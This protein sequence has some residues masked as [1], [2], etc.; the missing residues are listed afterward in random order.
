[1]ASLARVAGS[2]IAAFGGAILAPLLVYLGISIPFPATALGLVIVALV[3]AILCRSFTTASI[4]SIAGILAGLIVWL[5]LIYNP[6]MDAIVGAV[7]G[8]LL[9]DPTLA[10]ILLLAAMALVS[11]AV[12]LALSPR[13]EV[14]KAA[15]E[16]ESEEGVAVE[17]PPAAESEKS[18]A[19][20]EV[21]AVE[22]HRGEAPAVAAEVEAPTAGEEVVYVKCIHCGEPVPEEAVYCPHCGKRVKA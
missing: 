11:G 22:P 18:V 16:R 17:V 8:N 2:I 14:I 12:G 13:E 3:P 5:T 15:L 1:M 19:E 10:Y 6:V 4:A 9:V 7:A 20:G 21:G